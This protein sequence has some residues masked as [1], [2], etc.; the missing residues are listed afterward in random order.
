MFEKF[1][2]VMPNVKKSILRHFYRDLTADQSASSS[3]SEQEVDEQLC[4]LFEYRFNL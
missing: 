3:L 4:A 2:L 1:G